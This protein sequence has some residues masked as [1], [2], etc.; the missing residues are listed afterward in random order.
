MYD[1]GVYLCVGCNIN[2]TFLDLTKA[3]KINF[4]QGCIETDSGSTLDY[5]F[6]I[7]SKDFL[8]Y[9]KQDFKTNDKEGI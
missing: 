7:S 4:A 1:G 8:S 5:S 2:M 6:E 3:V 9:G